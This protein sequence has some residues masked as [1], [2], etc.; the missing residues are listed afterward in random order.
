MLNRVSQKGTELT[1]PSWV[2]LFIQG[3]TYFHY[4]KQYNKIRSFL[5][6]D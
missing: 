2:F 5:H 6:K 4:T 1:F 3:V